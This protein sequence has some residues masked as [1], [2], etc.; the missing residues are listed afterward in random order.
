MTWDAEKVDQSC[1]H[2]DKWLSA[3]LFVVYTDQVSFTLK[4]ML[5]V[6]DH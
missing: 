6:S 3:C 4:G 2:L 1:W 5:E